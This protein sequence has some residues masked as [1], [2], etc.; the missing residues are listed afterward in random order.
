[1]AKR[2]NRWVLFVV[3]ISVGIVLIGVIMFVRQIAEE[4]SRVAALE[5]PTPEQWELSKKTMETIVYEN[6]LPGKWRSSVDSSV[7]EFGW[8][9]SF[10]LSNDTNVYF[11]SIIKPNSNSYLIIRQMEGDTIFTIDSITGS[12]NRM[13]QYVQVEAYENRIISLDEKCLT[14]ASFINDSTAIKFEKVE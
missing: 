9:R 13:I 2:K 5:A 12:R 6:L 10:N 11:Y 8:A 1:M 4:F 14:L 3:L 7:I